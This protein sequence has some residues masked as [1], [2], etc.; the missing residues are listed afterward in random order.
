MP[1]LIITLLLASALC[2]QELYQIPDNVQTRWF[3]PENPEGRVGFAGQ[4][5]A[6][7]K[8]RPSIPV[9]AGE[10]IVL[11]EVKGSSGAVRRIWMTI[12][13]RN[14]QMLR[15]L[16]LE[17]YWD[18]ESRP[19]INVP[20]GD[21]FGVGLGRMATFSSVFFASPEG[22]SFNCFIPMPFRKGAKIV[23]I[24]DSDRNLGMLFYDVDV[25][26]GDRHGKNVGYL[27]AWYHREN[28][29]RMQQDYEI[30]PQVSGRGR[31][32]G[33]NI[34]AIADQK[35]YVKTW[36]GEGEVKIYLDGDR[37]LPTLSG[38]GTEDYIGTGWGQGAYSTPY[39]GCT[40]ADN[41]AM[42]YAFYRY[43]APD[44]VFFYKDVRVTIQQIGYAGAKQ[45]EQ[46]KQ[47]ATELF[48]AGPGLVP[49]DFSGPGLFER[50]DDW[51]SCAYFYLDRPGNDLPPVDPVAKRTDG[52]GSPGRRSGQ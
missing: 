41:G 34:G 6:G 21:F 30:L 18:N 14:P 2:G 5:N 24:N 46:M 29:T 27:H 16:R 47:A 3:S 45:L 49:Y 8:G 38:T 44:P 23:L 22:R 9:K 17:F 1:T 19:A 11:A 7:R 26:V 37:K 42:A 28:P 32:L 52:L 51:S 25:T 43:H 12:D 48:R 36:W 20:L 15:S 40:V 33:C 4:V 13:Q 39:T 35:R 50:Q 10:Q 31:F